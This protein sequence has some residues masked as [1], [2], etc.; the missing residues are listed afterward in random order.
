M[1]TTT[2]T[3]VNEPA[4]TSVLLQNGKTFQYTSNEPTSLEQIP[5]ID[6][7]CIYSDKL[8]DRKAVAEEVRRASHDIGFFYIV[9][10]G[11]DPSYK[12]QAF[13]KAKLFFELPEE[14]KMEVFTGRVP[15]EFVGYHPMEAYNRNQWKHRD[16][17][18]AFNLAYDASTDPEA[19]D[20]DE[21]SI[22]IWPSDQPEFKQAMYGYHTQ[23]LQLARR[24]TRIFALALHVPE[25][26]FDEYI[27]TPEAGMRIIHYP[28]QERSRDDQQ[29]IGAHTDVECF[30]IVT[31][32]DS[33]GLEVLSKQNSWIRANPVPGSMLVNIADCF[34]R[35]TNDFFVSTVHRVINQSG[36]ERFSVPF[37]FGF[38]R[39]KVLETV[40][41][42]V[43]DEN[44]AKY[45]AMTA[46]EYYAWRT[47]RQKSDGTKGENDASKQ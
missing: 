24:L 26:A 30:T 25:D 28:S 44:P 7:A 39:S 47:N 27:K 22:S 46:G 5:V 38:D 35:Q 6:I 15:G 21:P 34:M 17:S 32:D 19:V 13:E 8:E 36:K 33:G 29:G 37:F 3:S 18:E 43:S 31:Q 16:L 12:E 1:S 20:K 11:I 42:C 23:L 10:H 4:T 2:T 41:T 14:Q 45:P 9:N 40:P